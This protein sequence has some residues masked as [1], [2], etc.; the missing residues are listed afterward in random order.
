MIALLMLALQA[1]AAPRGAPPAAVVAAAPAIPPAQRA[2]AEELVRIAR[3]DE[4][5]RA[6]TAKQIAQM[7]SG[8]Q[9]SAQLDQNPA[10]R[11]QR[12][13]NPQAWDAAI[14]RIAAKQ[15]D[16]FAALIAEMAPL[17]REH[18]VE[19]YATNFTPAQL[20]DLVAFYRTPLG[21]TLVE[22]LPAV[23]EQTM[24]WIQQELPRRIA[25]VIAALQPELQRELGALMPQPPK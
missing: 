18:A 16:A 4:M 14:G 9:L 13:K 22:K 8:A 12:A 23:T 15:A 3:I 7:R 19:A 24:A 11:A 5:M 1:P 25:P 6:T 17:A 2:A 10:I 20:R 21:Q